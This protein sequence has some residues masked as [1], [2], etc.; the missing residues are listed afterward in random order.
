MGR[1]GS[2]EVLLAVAGLAMVIMVVGNACSTDEQQQAVPSSTS[3]VVPGSTSTS[4]APTTSA[5]WMP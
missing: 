4:T 1:R 2:L 5:S 3:T